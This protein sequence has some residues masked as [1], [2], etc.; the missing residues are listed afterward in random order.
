MMSARFAL[1]LPTPVGRKFFRLHP[2]WGLAV[3]SIILALL[4]ALIIISYYANQAYRHNQQ[5]QSDLTQLGQQQQKL[6]H[7][8]DQQLL[9]NQ[10]LNQKVNDRN[11]KLNYLSSR[12]HDVES[13]LGIMEEKIEPDSDYETDVPFE[14][15]QPAP[16]V[17]LEQRVNAAAINS[18]VQASLLRMIPNNKPLDFSRVSSQ[19][20]QRIHP[21]TGK[22][23]K[24][25]GL[26]LTCKTGQPIFAPADGV[27][28]YTRQSSQ[29]YGNLLKV[30]HS[31]GFMTLY[32]HL[33]RFFVNNGQFVE[34]GDLIAACGNSGIST[35][36]HL[37][38]EIRFL[39]RTLNPTPFL[40]WD[41]NNFK[42]LFE[43]E[44][45]IN[46]A[47]LVGNINTVVE[48]QMLLTRMAPQSD[49][50][51]VLYKDNQTEPPPL[52]AHPKLE[53]DQVAQRNLHFNNDLQQFGI[54]EDGWST[55]TSS[56]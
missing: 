12:I 52:A 29:G 18:A 13:V 43:Q 14:E 10:F 26:D 32:A 30:R 24:H 21:L 16:L 31:F 20:G 25:L 39:G 15:P 2:I 5:L 17:R 36:P 22:R 1:I 4:L 47:A 44:Q 49:N 11:D 34:K 35:G 38:Y 37:H 33:Q 41:S 7:Q 42:Q 51:D 6:R 9:K 55:V 23:Q 54:S 8:Y 28:E 40:D 53:M 56:E 19:Y 27:I 46:W 45:S 50:N 48:M 3:I